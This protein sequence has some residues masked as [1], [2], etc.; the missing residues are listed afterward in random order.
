ME[1]IILYSE[2]LKDA[3]FKFTDKCFCEIGKAFEPEGRHSFYNNIEKEFDCFWCL[4]KDGNVAGT[5]ALKRI[6]ESTSELKALY[7]SREMRGKGFGYMLLNQTVD[8]ARSRE[9]KRIVLDSMSKYTDALRLYEKY[10]FK[11]IERYNDNQY[12][13]VFM[14]YVL[15]S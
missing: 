11:H 9:Y 14:E 5:A 6:D 13:D 15:K 3:V 12:A 4:L 1:Q 8:Y 7:L 10:G 2:S